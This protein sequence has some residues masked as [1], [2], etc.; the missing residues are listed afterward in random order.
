MIIY[1]LVYGKNAY[2]Y[3]ACDLLLG[4]LKAFEGV[5]KSDF[6]TNFQDNPM[7]NDVVSHL[8]EEHFISIDHWY[9]SITSKGKLFIDNGGY[10]RIA[11]GRV[12]SAIG[13]ILGLVASITAVIAFFGFQF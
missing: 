3:S 12:V 4:T 10:K 5:L 7:F 8:L 6:Y 11:I 9:V 13:F 1:K 2:Y